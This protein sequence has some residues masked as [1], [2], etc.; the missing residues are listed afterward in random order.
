MKSVVSYAKSR[1][2]QES[3]SLLPLMIIIFLI[4][5]FSYMVAS[6][7]FTASMAKLRLERWG[8]DLV[9]S[10]YRE[11][12]YEKYFFDN[13]INPS[14]GDRVFIPVECDSLLK[15]LSKSVG[16]FPNGIALEKFECQ[17]GQLKVTISNRIE[18]PFYPA[19]LSNVDAKVV[20]HVGGGLQRVRGN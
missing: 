8:E 10:L 20:V 11:I 19:S 16:D 4:A 9:A 7:V 18:F 3:G 6:N 12:S 14:F 5:L 1:A 13:N 2:H 17:N 15:N